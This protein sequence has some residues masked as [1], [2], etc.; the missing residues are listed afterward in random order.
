MVA[1][2]EQ[3]ECRREI[4][5]ILAHEPGGDLVS[6]RQRFDLGLVP[7]SAFLS[8][9]CDDQAGSAQFR[10]VSWVAFVAGDEKGIHVGDG[11]VI[12]EDLGQR[13]D[14]SAFAIRPLAV[15][16]DEDVLVDEAS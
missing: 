16:E 6:T 9:L 2:D 7:A 5:K 1:G 10:K 11:G 12:A 13:V 3:L 14:K 8:F 15:S 4:E